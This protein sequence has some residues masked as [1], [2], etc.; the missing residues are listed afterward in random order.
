[1]AELTLEEFTA[2]FSN[3]SESTIEEALYYWTSHSG[4]RVLQTK[5]ASVDGE[6]RH[7]WFVHGLQEG[8]VL[9]HEDSATQ[10]SAQ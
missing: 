3:I 2:A 8:F 1:M 6:D 4:Q 5:V 10:K 7:V 9:G